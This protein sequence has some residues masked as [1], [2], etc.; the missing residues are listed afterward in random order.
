[1]QNAD[2]YRQFAETLTAAAESAQAATREVILGAARAWTALAEAEERAARGET[3]V[4]D[5]REAGER[6]RR[7]A[8]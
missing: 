1:M 6:L 7:Q 2:R 3:N 8:R 4:V 5:L